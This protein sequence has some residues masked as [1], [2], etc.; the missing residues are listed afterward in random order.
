MVTHIPQT[1][2][3]YIY[4]QFPGPS[5]SLSQYNTFSFYMYFFFM[6]LQILADITSSMTCDLIFFLL[7]WNLCTKLGVWNLVYSPI[8]VL[9][10]SWVSNS[11]KEVDHQENPWILNSIGLQLKLILYSFFNWFKSCSD[12]INLNVMTLYGW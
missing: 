10:C 1:V 12:I 2:F 6:N 11:N 3:L 9:Q 7:H 8:K 5:V 4:R